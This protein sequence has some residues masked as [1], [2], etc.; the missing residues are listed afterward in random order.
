[1]DKNTLIDLIKSYD[2]I[3]DD[4]ICNGEIIKKGNYIVTTGIGIY[5]Y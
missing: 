2:F 5:Y 3:F 4:S 1:M